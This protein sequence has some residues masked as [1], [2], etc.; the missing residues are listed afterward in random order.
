[1]K[2]KLGV[3][4]WLS[5]LFLFLLFAAAI[6]GP[7]FLPDPNKSLGASFL[8]AGGQFLLGTDE[9]G[10]DI[11]AR[12][13]SG[14]RFSL[15]IGI[16]T[17]LLSVSFGVLVGVIGEMGPKWIATPLMRFTDG[18][19][20]F[21]DLL[22][23]ILIVGI[24]GAGVFPVI[25]ALAITGW[26]S[27]ARLVRGQVATLKERE[28]VQASLALGAKPA[29][30][31]VRHILPHLAGLLLAVSMVDL[32]AVILAESTLSFLGIGVQ[33]P[34][35]S[36]G[37]MINIARQKIFDMPILLVWPCLILS[38]TIFALNFVGDG[39]RTLTDPRSR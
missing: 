30:V 19:F 31:T 29:Y 38:L 28:F 16:T 3:V 33:P 25:V 10:R 1:V 37:Q 8:P 15:F 14:A 11:F 13:I 20:A 39:L 18:M 7:N 9:Q 35:P 27:V 6:I 26:P 21:P 32:A 22:L 36:W 23:A 24:F 12:L 2:V 34:D 4:F 5:A 17:I